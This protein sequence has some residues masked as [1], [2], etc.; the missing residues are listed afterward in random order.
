ME[1][2]IRHLKLNKRVSI[3]MVVLLSTISI[4]AQKYKAQNPVEG[5]IVTNTGDTIQGTI[6]YLSEEK[7]AMSCMFKGK[8]ENDFR[9]YTPNDIQSYRL[10]NN[11]VFYV[12]RNYPVDRVSRTFFAEFLLQGSVSLYHYFDGQQ[13]YYFLEDEKGEIA[14]IKQAEDEKEL[15]TTPGEMGRARGMKV[16]QASQ[17]LQQSPQAVNDLQ[18]KD[19]TSRNLTSIVRQYNETFCS[20]WGDCVQFQYDEKASKTAKPRL[21]LE[22]GLAYW[23]SKNTD[24]AGTGTSLQPTIGIGIDLDFPRYG[25]KLTPQF[26]LHLSRLSHT[27]K[28]FYFKNSYNTDGDK[29]VVH[30]NYYD[31]KQQGYNVLVQMGCLHRLAMGESKN[32]LLLQWAI[33]PGYMLGFKSESEVGDEDTSSFPLF[34]IHAGVGFEI[35]TGSHHLNILLGYDWL[36]SKDAIIDRL[37]GISLKIAWIK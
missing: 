14:Q 20:S 2:R 23:M 12:R 26:M 16:M 36:K 37:Q 10:L 8:A 4:S 22:A 11:G 29:V 9:Q 15:Q 25:R 3:L 35:P 30:T 17:M 28:N 33:E 6:D 13:H 5:F 7:C 32:N 19:L 34:G 24:V 27:I 21:R 1:H 31:A 18:H